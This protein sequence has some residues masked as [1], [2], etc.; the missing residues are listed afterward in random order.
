MKILN[1]SICICLSIMICYPNFLSADENRRKSDEGRLQSFIQ[2]F[3]DENFQDP[4]L[5]QTSY[6]I[7][8][9]GSR[10]Q[11]GDI[12][13]Y[14]HRARTGLSQCARKVFW[15][16]NYDKSDAPFTISFSGRVDRIKLQGNVQGTV[17]FGAGAELVIQERFSPTADV[18]EV[19]QDGIE[20][21]ARI[22]DIE[23]PIS[24]RCQDLAHYIRTTYVAGTYVT[25]VIWLTGVLEG[26]YSLSLSGKGDISLDADQVKDLIENNSRLGFL[27]NFI[28]FEGELSGQAA[29]TTE[30]Q[31]LFSFQAKPNIATAFRPGRINRREAQ[32]LLDAYD[33]ANN[34][35][36]EQGDPNF[37][38]A[39]TSEEAANALDKLQASS[40]QFGPVIFADGGSVILTLFGGEET[41][42][43]EAYI[44]EVPDEAARLVRAVS[45]IFFISFLDNSA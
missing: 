12:V 23:D 42:P 29:R 17:N 4:R 39:S 31:T 16:D 6:I 40:D 22:A 18:F 41:L 27:T 33:D 5:G 24:A 45:N 14:E 9:P 37:E 11:A 32:Q 30:T 36:V 19:W 8:Y 3:L 35:L 43:Y 25:N 7:A 28:S 15:K 1:P 20:Y 2:E 21:E 10:M 13:N 26:F 34:A 44:A 38:T